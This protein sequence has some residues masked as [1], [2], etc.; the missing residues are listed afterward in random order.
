MSLA[1]PEDSEASYDEP[2]PKP[3]P[4]PK[5]GSDETVSGALSDADTEEPQSRRAASVGA[6]DAWVHPSVCAQGGEGAPWKRGRVR[7]PD[8]AP[9]DGRP[10]VRARSLAEEP[11]QTRT[12]ETQ[13]AEAKVLQL[14]DVLQPQ[15]AEALLG[16][17]RREPRRPYARRVFWFCCCGF[18]E[19]YTFFVFLLNFVVQNVSH[20]MV[21]QSVVTKAR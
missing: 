15:A 9:V 8:R 13:K 21:F 20:E 12:V 11:L 10:R 6:R 17:F 3:K 5:S 2:A 19:K 7:G 18:D 4:T 16:H 14:S 1:G